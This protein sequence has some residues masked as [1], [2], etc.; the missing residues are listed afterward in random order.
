MLEHLFARLSGSRSSEMRAERSARRE[1]VSTLCLELMCRY[2]SFADH[3][4]SI[5]A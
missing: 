3:V 4:Y 1:V 5:S 2:M